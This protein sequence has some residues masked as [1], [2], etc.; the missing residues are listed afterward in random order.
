MKKIFLS[1][2]LALTLLPAAC[3][4]STS[5]EAAL[6]LYYQRTVSKHT[7]PP[8]TLW[9]MQV[10][11]ARKEKIETKSKPAI[12]KAVFMSPEYLT[13]NR[14]NGQQEYKF[15]GSYRRQTVSFQGTVDDPEERGWRGMLSPK[16][17]KKNRDMILGEF[18]TYINKTWI[19]NMYR[20]FY[21][22]YGTNNNQSA[23]AKIKKTD[24]R[25][26]A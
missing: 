18:P 17:R 4:A 21:K 6:R 8:E 14:S 19:N 10:K 2:I 25:K 3:H 9:W 22:R 24:R 12:Y 15:N 16:S 26:A 7:P 20:A 11:P 5:L 1:L 23:E 13:F